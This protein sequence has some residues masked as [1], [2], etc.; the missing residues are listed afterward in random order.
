LLLLNIHE[1]EYRIKRD[2]SIL[3]EVTVMNGAHKFKIA[4]I[5]GPE[6]RVALF[7]FK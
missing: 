7:I 3:A 1:K 4:F 6:C 2:F 5:I